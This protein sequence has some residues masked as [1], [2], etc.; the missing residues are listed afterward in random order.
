[1]IFSPSL[2]GPCRCR[3]GAD[4]PQV[5]RAELVV[6]SLVSSPNASQ[7]RV[8]CFIRYP[9][10]KGWILTKHS[11]RNNK[12]SPMLIGLNGLHLTSV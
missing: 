12:D 10:V 11:Y 4:V 5:L 9:P 3:Q 1:M 2:R 7:Y 6:G 8:M